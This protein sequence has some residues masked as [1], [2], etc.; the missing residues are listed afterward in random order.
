MPSQRILI[1]DDEENIRR[2]MQM[3]LETEGYRVGT[4]ADGPEGLVRFR[5]RE[6]WDLVLLDQ[7]M[8]G[9]EGLEVLRAIH[10]I[11]PAARVVMVTAYATIELAVDAMKA[12]ATDFLRKPFTPDV[13]RGAVR[14]A[15]AA[16]PADADLELPVPPAAPAKAGPPLVTFRTLNG[17]SMWPIEVPEEEETTDALRIRRAFEV[18]APNGAL[19]RTAVDICTSVQQL[20]NEELP[21]ELAPTDPLWETICRH[22]LANLLWRTAQMPPETLV[23]YALSHEELEYIRR[24]SGMTWRART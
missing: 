1:I 21:H 13:L 11:D 18:Q 23:V 3:A 19:Q 8:P 7:R 5:E 14:G 16:H 4:A 2:T 15:L 24:A 9:M 17:F 20:L 12:G 10:E 6:G 22:V